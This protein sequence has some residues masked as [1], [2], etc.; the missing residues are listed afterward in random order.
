MATE[1]LR[2][3]YGSFTEKHGHPPTKE[4]VEDGFV[5]CACGF[6]LSPSDFEYYTY[7][8]ERCEKRTAHGVMQFE[9]NFET[10]SVEPNGTPR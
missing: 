4:E 2:L 5:M 8:C 9:R 7:Q 6:T 1:D 3:T 10:L